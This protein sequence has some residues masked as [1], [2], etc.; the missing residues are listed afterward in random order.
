M[1]CALWCPSVVTWL[2]ADGSRALV[3][4]TIG[5]PGARCPRPPQVQTEEAE[6]NRERPHA[7]LAVV[8]PHIHTRTHTRTPPHHTHTHHHT[9]TPSHTH[10]HT[11]THTHTITPSHHRTITHT[12]HHHTHT[13]THTITQTHTI[14]HT[15]TRTITHHCAQHLRVAQ[16]CKWRTKNGPRTLRPPDCAGTGGQD[17]AERHGPWGRGSFSWRR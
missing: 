15:I 2:Y 17:G 14:T 9:H 12:P 7:D 11:I 3:R 5:L 10:Y 8:G 16:P 4:A 13:H 1:P 6:D